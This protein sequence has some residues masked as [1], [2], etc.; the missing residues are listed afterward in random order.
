M[1]WPPPDE[2]FY[3]RPDGV[4]ERLS[5][6]AVVLR[7]S[8]VG[9]LLA[10]VVEPGEIRQLP[11]GGIEPGESPQEALH[12]ELGEE[13]GLSRVEVR[14]ELGTSE[15][16]NYARARWQV[17]RYFLGVTEEE[18]AAPLEPGYRLEW[19]PLSAPPELFWPEQTRLVREVAKVKASLLSS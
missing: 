17:T 15:R 3:V 11:K 6:G 19:H 9:W 2:T 1:S 4:P 7:S 14:A 12:R 8:P 18:G 16:L 13:A 5:V 10:V